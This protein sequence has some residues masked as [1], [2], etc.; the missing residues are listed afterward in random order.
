MV[1][2]ML[3]VNE[4]YHSFQGEGPNTGKPTMFVRFVGCNLKCPGW[5]CDT[6][7]AIDPKLYRK[8]MVSYHEDG[9]S[10]EFSDYVCDQWRAGETICFT[11]G[12]VTLQPIQDLQYA[13]GRIKHHTGA[14]MEL[15]TN[16]TLKVPANFYD[17]FNTV[18]F[19]WKLPGSGEV[20]DL[21][22]DVRRARDTN[23]LLLRPT[24]AVKFTV[25]D[26]ADFDWARAKWLGSFPVRCF[27][28]T[29]SPLI[30]CGPVWGSVSAEEVA[31]WIMDARL[32]WRL[33]VQTH[34]FIWDPD[35][36]RV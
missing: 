27:P 35:K 25:K 17:W 11:G 18:I 3:R 12:E 19:D 14:D 21:N 6:Q 8:D 26:W 9:P 28:G 7:H 13:L 10:A 33:N 31:Q 30:Y 32:P 4:I 29:D 22:G 24:D 16:G 34:K 36:R 5:P 15:F 2:Q 23:Y 20:F 1:K